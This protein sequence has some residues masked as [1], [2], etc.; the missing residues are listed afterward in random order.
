VGLDNNG[1]EHDEVQDGTAG[2]D[3]GNETNDDEGDFDNSAQSP[4]PPT[5]ILGLASKQSRPTRPTTSVLRPIGAKMR[6]KQGPNGR[7]SGAMRILK[8]NPLQACRLLAV[9]LLLH[10][11]RAHLP[12]I[13]RRLIKAPPKSGM[14]PIQAISTSSRASASRMILPPILWRSSTCT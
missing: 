6:K 10:L 9:L 2:H 7:L 8:T 3:E 5:I 1:N 12:Q 4:P 13:L 14:S 11:P